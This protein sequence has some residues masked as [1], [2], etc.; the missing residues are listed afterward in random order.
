MFL[1]VDNVKVFRRVM[2]Y[3]PHFYCVCVCV[4]IIIF[5][6]LLFCTVCWF[7]WLVRYSGNDVS[8]ICKVL[9]TLIPVAGICTG[10]SGH[11]WRVYHPGVYPGHSAWPSLCG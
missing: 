2:Y 1:N 6:Y 11:L 8:H 7:R 10:I 4:F 3:A 9:A 5:N